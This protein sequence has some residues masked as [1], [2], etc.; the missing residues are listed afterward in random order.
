MSPKSFNRQ[1]VNIASSISREFNFFHFTISLT[2]SKWETNVW[3]RV[4][5][6]RLDRGDWITVETVTLELR[7]NENWLKYR[8][9][10]IRARKGFYPLNKSRPSIPVFLNISLHY[11]CT[12]SSFPLFYLFPR[13]RQ[14]STFVQNYSTVW[15][16]RRVNLLPSKIRCERNYVKISSNTIGKYFRV[17]ENLNFIIKITIIHRNAASNWKIFII[18]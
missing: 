12:Q 8:K 9:D 15:I 7:C 11:F 10:L 2:I 14:C 18:A 6:T 3:F 17:N 5:L 13:V 4:E 1:C 16:F